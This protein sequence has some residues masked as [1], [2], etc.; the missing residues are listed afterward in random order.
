[1]SRFIVFSTSDHR[2]KKVDVTGGPSTTLCDVDDSVVGGSWKSS[3]VILFGTISRGLMQV[4]ES[5][6]KAS[7]VTKPTTESPLHAYPT[8]LLT[9]RHPRKT[10]SSPGWIQK[11]AQTEP[12][13]NRV[14]SVPSPCR[15]LP[16]GPRL[17]NGTVTARTFGWSTC[18]GADRK[19]SH[20]RG[21]FP[22]SRRS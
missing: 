1:D 6:G 7:P 20:L 3:G 8:F 19:S 16:I 5:G 2:L 18:C 21:T 13:L 12:L 17:S 22:V 4:S 10:T 11:E 14:H 15:R 9:C